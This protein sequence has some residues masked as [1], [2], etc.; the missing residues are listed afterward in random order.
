MMINTLVLLGGLVWGLWKFFSGRN[1]RHLFVLIF[2]VAF[3]LSQWPLFLPTKFTFS[4]TSFAAAGFL[5][6]EYPYRKG[7]KS[8]LP[9]TYI[10]I[11]LFIMFGILFFGEGWLT[12]AKRSVS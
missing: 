2:L 6:Y 3:I 7:L 9:M 10:Y 5:I 11:F 12:L 8:G 1:L 4:I